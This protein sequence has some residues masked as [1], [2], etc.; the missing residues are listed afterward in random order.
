MRAWLTASAA[1]ALAAACGEQRRPIGEECLRDEDCLS[2]V[3]AA[4]T[5]VSAPT[6]VTG[7]SDPPGDEEPR[8]PMDAGA[9]DASEAADS[10]ADL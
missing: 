2:S 6:L 5:C 10:G 9:S 8:I 4:R 7:A 3:C 1:F